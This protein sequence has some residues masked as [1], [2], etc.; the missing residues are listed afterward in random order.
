MSNRK[1]ISSHDCQN[2]QVLLCQH[3]ICVVTVV[4]QNTKNLIISYTHYFLEKSLGTF[5]M[6]SNVTVSE[7]SLPNSSGNEDRTIVDKNGNR[8]TKLDCDFIMTNDKSEKHSVYQCIKKNSQKCFGK[9]ALNDQSNGLAKV[10]QLHSCRWSYD[11]A[12]EFCYL[13][14]GCNKYIKTGYH[15]PVQTWKERWNLLWSIHSETLNIWTH[16]IGIII[17]AYCLW[18]TIFFM[19][20]SD[21]WIS[22]LHDFAGLTMF[23]S[24]TAYHWL[25]KSRK[26]IQIFT[27]A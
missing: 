26:R 27:T 12:S 4:E 24:S 2:P 5:K 15:P 13:R 25:H 6:Y 21:Y 1:F 20:G 18:N 17:A 11:E 10:I 16:A 9:I 3:H 7:L 22:I 8:Y 23:L 14:Y 19:D